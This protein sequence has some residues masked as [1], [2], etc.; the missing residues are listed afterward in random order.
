MSNVVAVIPAR[1]SSTRLPGKPLMDICG[2]PMVRHVFERVKRC[3]EVD[4]VIVATDDKRVAEAVEAFGGYAVLTSPAHISG[5]DRVAE[6][7]KGMKCS[8]VVNVQGDEPLIRPEVIDAT[9]SFL[10]SREEASVATACSSLDDQHE[11]F[12]PNVVKVVLDK[13]GR[14]LYFSR[15]P[16][17]YLRNGGGHERPAYR[18]IGLYAYRSSFLYEFANMKPTPLELSEKLEQLRILE[19]GYDI[20]VAIVDYEP[21]G[22]DT[23]EDLE[24]VRAIISEEKRGKR[25]E[26]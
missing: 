26:D 4:K 17:P 7:A 6:A 16:I 12:N 1:Y 23:V 3:G 8:I 10:K 21:I 9:V 14:A 18:H 15:A 5:T 2:W 20:H 11:I 19:N 22:V 13:F 25:L 24:R